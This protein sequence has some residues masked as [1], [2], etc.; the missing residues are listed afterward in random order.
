MKQL[1]IF[2]VFILFLNTF[3]LISTSQN[4]EYEIPQIIKKA[5]IQDLNINKERSFR[6]LTAQEDEEMK[7]YEKIEDEFNP[8]KILNW[9]NNVQKK[10]ITNMKKEEVNHILDGIKV[11]SSKIQNYLTHSSR[12]IGANINMIELK[13]DE[14]DKIDTKISSLKPDY[15]NELERINNGSGTL[16]NALQNEKA[17]IKKVLTKLKTKKSDL[18]K[19]ANRT[20]SVAKKIQKINST[21]QV[22]D[23]IDTLLVPFIKFENFENSRKKLMTVVDTTMSSMNVDKEL[24]EDNDVSKLARKIIEDNWKNIIEEKVELKEEKEKEKEDKVDKKTE[25]IQDSKED[26]T[27]DYDDEDEE[28]DEEEFDSK[29]AQKIQEKL[30]EEKPKR[31]NLASKRKNEKKVSKIMTLRKHTNVI[32]ETTDETITSKFNRGNPNNMKEED[33]TKL[34][35]DDDDKE[36]DN[37]DGD[38]SLKKEVEGDDTSESEGNNLGPNSSEEDDDDKE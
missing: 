9:I 26:F 37:L 1:A 7:K 28:D 20:T 35:N 33:P 25:K 29:D 4:E 21:R 34:D 30:D 27:E 32:D 11:A 8:E 36:K 24:S 12:V 2:L 38:E 19:T 10:D 22:K 17:A 3:V 18:K 14:I 31:K 23:K 13:V 15:K 5:K 6:K 16:I